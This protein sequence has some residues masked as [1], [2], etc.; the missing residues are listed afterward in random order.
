MLI[1]GMPEN[2]V[3]MMHRLTG[4]FFRPDDPD[5]ARPTEGHAIGEAGAELF[6]YLRGC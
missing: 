5:I 6:A 1:L 3:K 4:Q 2:D